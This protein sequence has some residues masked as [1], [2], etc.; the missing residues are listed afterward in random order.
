MPQRA[1]TRLRSS[2]LPGGSSLGWPQREQ[3]RIGLGLPPPAGVHDR[4][5]RMSA[6]TPS[7]QNTDR[8]ASRAAHEECTSSDPD[9]AQDR[10]RNGA[11]TGIASSQE[12]TKE[13]NAR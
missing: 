13:Q 10:E 1:Q 7:D 3:K 9:P 2:G 6:V 12:A 4:S 8:T 11:A 5:M